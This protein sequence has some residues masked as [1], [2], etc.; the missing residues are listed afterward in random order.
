MIE[1]VEGLKRGDKKAIDGGIFELVVYL[2]N[3]KKELYYR[4]DGMHHR[5]PHQYYE[6]A[7]VY[8]KEVEILNIIENYL[9]PYLEMNPMELFGIMSSDEK[10]ALK[11]ITRQKR[12]PKEMGDEIGQ[13]VGIIP[14]GGKIKRH[15]KSKRQSRRNKKGHDKSKRSRVKKI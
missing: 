15:N 6:G 12:L 3:V 8:E 2:T 13:Y 14:K 1:I 4:H 7:E 11:S 5:E 10:M 9:L